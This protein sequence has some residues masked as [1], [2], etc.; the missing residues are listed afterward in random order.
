MDLTRDADNFFNFF[1]LFLFFFRKVVD[2]FLRVWYSI[3]V[4]GKDKP[5][6]SQEK[7]TGYKKRLNAC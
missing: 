4:S 1:Y 7:F 3:I 2:K 5:Q 6:Q